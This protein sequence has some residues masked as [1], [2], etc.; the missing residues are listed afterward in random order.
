MSQ[1]SGNA[2]TARQHERVDTAP[3][4]L[5]HG[6]AESSTVGVSVGGVGFSVGVGVGVKSPSHGNATHCVHAPLVTSIALAGHQDHGKGNSRA[7]SQH[8]ACV[9]SVMNR[10]S[11]M[12]STAS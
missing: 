6:K 8:A 12:H 9:L 4:V 1:V 10:G 2:P 3:P 7:M 5:R 11:A